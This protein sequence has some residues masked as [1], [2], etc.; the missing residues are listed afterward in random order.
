[1]SW[2]GDEMIVSFSR[3][4]VIGPVVVLTCAAL[5]IAFLA[6]MASADAAPL[7]ERVSGNFSD[8]AIDTNGDGMAANLVSGQVS[9]ENGPSYEGIWEIAFVPAD[10]ACRPGEAQGAVV[11]Y[12]I[13]RGHR[14]GDL[15]YSALD[16]TMRNTACFDIATGTARLS[17]NAVVTGGTGRFATSSG[18][19]E[20]NL[21]VRLLL[22]DAGGGIAHG[23]FTGNILGDAG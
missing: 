22:P 13:V 5:V 6:V 1:M 20:A 16:D 15:Q 7:R 11:A 12:S 9:G 10:G 2:K 8:T 23:A 18:S 17:I 14:N 21:D 3:R 4:L 19:Y